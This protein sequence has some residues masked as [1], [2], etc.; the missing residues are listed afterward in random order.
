MSSNEKLN[1]SDSSTQV[2]TLDSS[3]HK[4]PS[5][6]YARYAILAAIVFTAGIAGLV[7]WKYKAA[8]NYDQISIF[9]PVSG[10]LS[11][12]YSKFAVRDA[13]NLEL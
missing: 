4:R 13:F 6:K 3:P 5:V 12:P 7:I 11:I 10:N 8:P 2:L 1:E 9:A